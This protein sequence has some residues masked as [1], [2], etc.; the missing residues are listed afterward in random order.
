M[1]G[2]CG[3]GEKEGAGA[4]WTVY[5]FTF[6]PATPG[7]SQSAQS[8]LGQLVEWMLAF[9]V[10]LFFDLPVSNRCRIH[11]LPPILGHLTESL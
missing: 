9:F 7:R 6:F 4:V 3:S 10:F 11:G 2:E 8:K 5:K 1:A